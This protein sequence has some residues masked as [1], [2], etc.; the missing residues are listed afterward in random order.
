MIRCLIVGSL[1]FGCFTVLAFAGGLV[2]QHLLF[3]TAATAAAGWLLFL[4]PIIGLIALVLGVLIGYLMVRGVELGQLKRYYTIV[5][6]L[7]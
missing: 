3:P 2:L 6:N 7:S 4:T 5:L 1:S